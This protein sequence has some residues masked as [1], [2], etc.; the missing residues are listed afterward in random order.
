MNEQN[1]KYR[2][3][4]KNALYSN[5]DDK[6]SMDRLA[7]F[8]KRKS[9][10]FQSSYIY[11]GLS[12]FY[13][14]GPIGT[15]MLD[16]L[17]SLW[18]NYFFFM[19]QKIGINMHEMSCADIMPENVFIA[20]QHTKRFNDLVAVCAKNHVQRADHLIEQEL[21]NKG[22]NITNLSLEGKSKEELFSII[23]ENNIK[24]PICGSKI[25]EIRAQNLMFGLYVGT[26][27]KKA[28]LRPETAQSAFVNFKL[29]Y[30]ANRKK[31]PFAISIIGKAYRNEISPRKLLLRMREFNQAEIQIFFN[32]SDFDNFINFDEIKDYKLNIL[33]ADDRTQNTINFKKVKCRDLINRFEK[34]YLYYLAKIQSF[35]I[36]VLKIDSERFRFYEMNEKEKAFYNIYHCDIQLKLNTNSWTEVAGLHYRGDHDLSGHDKLSKESF[37]IKDEK[38]NNYFIPHVLELSFGLD[39]NLF[40]LIDLAYYYDKDR[41]N[42]VLRL[43]KHLSAYNVAVFP[44][45]TN[46]TEL[47]EKARQIYLNLI[48]LGLYNVFFDIK[49]SIGRRYARQDEI[50]TPYC[51]TVDFDTLKDD[52]VTVRYR[53]SKK[54]ERIKLNYLNDW[55]NKEFKLHFS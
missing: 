38:T 37:K 24:C 12:G 20:S 10:F 36:D 29:I 26:E 9:I 22:I 13:D 23:K 43:N 5:N 32:P 17:I 7:T 15:K 39:R 51:I 19:N 11:G 44:L 25:K 4:D 3:Q 48:K 30:E 1:N 53:D 21:Q 35:Y 6:I 41:D 18:K 42:V 40:A 54:Q 45:L 55:L 50:G 34:F 8:C 33:L 46:K 49:G 27:N 28:Y 47:V 2:E 52:T 31:L 16:K 14:Y